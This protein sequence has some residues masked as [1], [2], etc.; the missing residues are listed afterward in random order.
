MSIKTLKTLFL[1]L[2][3][4]SMIYSMAAATGP[5]PVKA[6]K[7]ITACLMKIVNEVVPLITLSFIII[8][9]LTHI[10]SAES[11]KQRIQA[12]RFI[13]MGV[14]GFL[15]VKIII[16]VAGMAP[17]DLNVSMCVPLY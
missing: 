3:V 11:K 5:D 2:L 10:T 8:G 1:A 12:R 14:G 15:F 4:L 9:G 6:G 17:F 13:I 7:K 16:A